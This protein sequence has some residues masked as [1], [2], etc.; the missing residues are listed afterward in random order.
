MK[1]PCLIRCLC[2]SA[3][4]F[5]ARAG[6]ASDAAHA[7]QLPYASVPDQLLNLPPDLSRLPQ[8]VLPRDLP[9]RRIPELI[10]FSSLADGQLTNRAVPLPEANTL[11]HLNFQQRRFGRLQAPS[12]KMSLFNP[13]VVLVKFRG[14]PHVSALR[15]EPMRE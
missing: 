2:F 15:V 13:E 7:I 10:L 12:G 3:A 1:L 8:P 14:L 5:L 9:G 6:G 4:L 11:A